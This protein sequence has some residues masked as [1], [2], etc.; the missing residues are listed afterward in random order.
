MAW[1]VKTTSKTMKTLKTILTAGAMACAS[2]VAAQT[3]PSGN[4]WH[5]MSVNE[6]N[7]LPLH[8]HFFAFENEAKAINGDKKASDR[9][10]SLDGTWRFHYVDN[11]ANRPTDFYRT[12]LD[13][14]AWATMS[15]PGM[16]ELNGY[17][18]P[19]YVNVGFAWRG[20][21]QNNPPEVP[22]KDN[23]VGS[24]R[25]TVNIPASW[26][27]RQVIAH[28]GSVTSCI[29]LYVN[30]Q[31]AG[32]SEDSKV[33]AEFDITPFVKTGDNLIAFQ[34]MRWCD[35]SYLEDQDFWR[36]SG[37][38]RDSYLYSREQ[39]NH[40]DNIK[41]NAT[42]DDNY[43][44]GIL[45]IDVEQTGKGTVTA[46]LLDADGRQVAKSKVNGH[47]TL[48][49]KQP[50]QWSAE[51][52]YLY[53]LVTTLAPKKGQKGEVIT[54]KVGFRR[55][56]IKNAQ[57]LV[58]GQPIIIKG[59]NRHEMDPD[60]G[61]VV[62]RERMLQDL[63]LMKRFNVNAVRTCHY[64]DDP[65]WYD[66]CDEYG[67][68]VVGEANVESHGFL[69]ERE[70]ASAK[71]Q[72]AQPIMERNQHNVSLLR[73]HPS[74]IIWSMGNET[75]MCSHFTNVNH[76][77][78]ANDNSRPVQYEPAGLGDDTDI[79]C[80]MYM[81][82]DDCKKYAG[83]ENVPK[84]LIQCEYAHAMGN[85]GGGFKEYMDLVRKLP[86]YQ[87]GFIWDFV[88]QGLRKEARSK[89]Q[90]S[91][92]STAYPVADLKPQASN[93]KP[94]IIDYTYGGDYNDYD[95]SDNNF[96]CNG[97]ISPDRV[98]NPHF[99]EV[100]YFYQNIWMS[101]DYYS[102][103]LLIHNENFFR[104]LDNVRLVIRYMEDGYFT[105]DSLVIDTIHV[106]PQGTQEI[107][108]TQRLHMT[109]VRDFL[110][111][112]EFQLK[113]DEPLIPAGSVVAYAQLDAT[114]GLHEVTPKKLKLHPGH[115]SAFEVIDKPDF[116]V[117]QLDGM[118]MKVAFDRTTGFMK[119]LI[120]NNLPI[121]GPGGELRPNFWR[122]VTDNDMGA[123]LQQRYAVWHNPQM[124]LESFDIRSKDKQ[125]TEVTAVYDMPEVK[126][127]LR[128]TYLLHV[129]GEVTVI[130]KM[131]TDPTAKV[132]DMFRFGMVM[133]L[134][135]DMDRSE[136]YGRGP[137]ENYIDRK[138]SQW[139]GIYK[140]T[141][142]EQFYPYVRPQETGLK[143]DVR[144]WWQRDGE[145]NGFEIEAGQ[146]NSLYM[147]ALHYDQET[148]DEGRDKR[149]RHPSELK[150]SEYTNLFI[151]SEHMGVACINSWGATPLPQHLV[152]YGDK[153]LTFT[154]TRKILSK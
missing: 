45:D 53:T 128:L 27:G 3:L 127:K 15:V 26:K 111:N 107:Q 118:A 145:G 61:Y 149:Q 123:R 100:G 117:I 74:I 134:P 119:G 132:S 67:F 21:F 25:R 46:V 110:M 108:I 80:P 19:E 94:Q 109:G 52:P 48:N 58:N 40:I 92:G 81:S 11:A 31:F 129:S 18:D 71:P 93:L 122:A 133:Q 150:K 140:Q 38:A 41:I 29:Y 139:L 62:S 73:N 84:P 72:F 66:L 146:L 49:V 65:L 9:Y 44:D 34:V 16:W 78:K 91:R 137:V 125:E 114:R 143:S 98:P 120:I 115:G 63:A 4:E 142:D 39:G 85:S 5:D 75:K 8:T 104:P 113:N 86:H 112:C 135:Y 64:P 101:K 1:V 106:E 57:L 47:L 130:Q 70:S 37:V 10:I 90:M 20:H 83:G 103:N 33:A 138:E 13:D 69:Y 136:F 59:V 24:Y 144:W 12:D 54:Q 17:G 22:L 154:I 55:V 96:N 42:L 95:P 131:T 152:K 23:H 6:V 51:I 153:E 97:L 14:S 56:E 35:G 88:D 82:Q 2:V 121:I 126:A 116:P 36:L 124:N 32:Y 99:Y 43:R 7:R 147:S 68:Y 148:L 30:G 89:E 28:F 105:G 76:W 151:D 79:F 141:A 77:I 87:G 102:A 60:G 50:R